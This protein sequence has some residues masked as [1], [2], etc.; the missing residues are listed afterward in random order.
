MEL[1]R[2]GLHAK[3]DRLN[4]QN[5]DRK[6]YKYGYLLIFACFFIY[7]S[8]MAAK[9][10][11]S[12]EVKYIIDMW[13]LTQA[14]AQM[15]NTFYFVPYGLV[16]VGLFFLMKKINI[17]KYLIVT[18]PFSALATA[19][20]GI[21]SS[22]EW[23]WLYFGLSGLFQAGIYCGCNYI[24]STYLPT[25]MLSTANK[26]MNTAYAMGTVIAYLL[27][28]FCISLDLWSLPYFVIGG[29][30]L[31][32]V[33]VFAIVT[34]FS[35]RF[36]HINQILDD[37]EKQVDT[38]MVDDEKP[39]FSVDTKKSRIIFYV[40]DLLMA[41]IITSL[42]Y[43]VMNFITSSLVDVHGVSQDVSIYVAIIAPITIV[44]GPM[45]T[46]SSCDKD[47]DFIR[48][49]IF[50]MLA[51]LPIP[52]LLAFFYDVN[53]F[54]YLALAIVFIVV[55]NGVKAIVLSV[56]TFKMRK[57]INAGSY[58][59]ISNA[60]ASVSAGVTPAILGW[61]KDVFGWSAVYFTVFGI[62]LFIVVA[63][64]LI[65]LWVCRLNKKTDAK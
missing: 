37:K 13:D 21:S 26:I 9:G 59:A 50:Y 22:I 23:V 4:L 64:I 14:K 43:G 38:K 32:S 56:M 3:N 20:I 57:I 35:A 15:A 24:L 6:R 48:E 40:I 16:Q 62:S 61:V 33:L 30:F 5:I 27:S 29:I 52:L 34:K 28:A 11:F 63:L 10:I 60:V 31:L 25:K 18:V 65:E 39:L 55:A 53:V 8:S 2:F 12:A 17:R 47:R 41:F 44:A 49:G 1:F 46:I 36:K 58:S 45:M 19:L 54:L 51:L 42:Y 7:M